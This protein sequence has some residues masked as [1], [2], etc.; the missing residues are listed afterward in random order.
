MIISTQ[1]KQLVDN[2]FS[3]NLTLPVYIVT[4]I[5]LIMCIWVPE[6]RCF[7]LDTRFDLYLLHVLLSIHVLI[8]IYS[9]Y[10]CRYTFWFIFTPCI[11]VDTRFDLYLLHVLLSIHV[12]IY[13]YSMYYCRYTFWFIITPCITVDTRFDLYLILNSSLSVFILE[14]IWKQMYG[15]RHRSIRPAC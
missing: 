1:T 3:L 2:V 15:V 11:T 7:T 9:M 5:R 6:L 4:N 14:W 12:L 10:Y 13:I 8:Y